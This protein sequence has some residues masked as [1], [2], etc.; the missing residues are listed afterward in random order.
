MCRARPL[1]YFGVVAEKESITLRFEADWLE[2]HPLTRADLEL[3]T[4]NL[5]EVGITLTVAED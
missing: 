1:P 4:Q 2:E 3:E 5:A